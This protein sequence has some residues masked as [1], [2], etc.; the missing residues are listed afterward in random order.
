[1]TT[2]NDRKDAFESKFAHDEANCA[3]QSHGSAQHKLFGLWAAVSLGQLEPM[4]RLRQERRAAIRGAGR[5]RA[6]ASA[7]GSRGRSPRPCRTVSC[8]APW[9]PAPRPSSSGD[10]EAG[11]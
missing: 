6:P 1:M 3:L 5:R 10:P 8:A 2:F 9:V 4:G 7:Q 11:R